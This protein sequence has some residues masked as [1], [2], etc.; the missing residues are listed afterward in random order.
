MRLYQLFKPRLFAEHQV[1][2]YE[3]LDRPLINILKSMEDAGIC[4]NTKALQGL[5][6]DFELKMRDYEQ[7]SYR[8]AGEEFNL[9]SP[10]QIGDILFGKLGAKGKKT[11]TGA[12]QTGA[13]I[14]EDLAA[15]GNELA[16]KILDW[17]AL[18]KLKSTYTDALLA[19]LD[20]Q[21]RVH[22]TYNQINTSTGRLASNNP[23]LQNI[24]IR[25]EEGKKIR[26]SFIA[27][28]GH[29]IIASDYS[30]VELRL[31][32]VVADVKGLKHSFA[33]NQ[34]IHAATASRVF[35]VPLNE[36][37]PNQRRH[38]KAI[39]FGIVYGISQFG[40]AKQIDVSNEEAKAYIDAY[41][42]EMP[43]IKQYMDDTI[44][45]ARKNGY[46][47]TPFGRKCTVNGI[48]DKNKRLSMNAERAAINAP[49]QGG[50]AD[51]IKMAMNAVF[52]ALKAGGFKTRMLLQVHD[53]LVFEAPEEEV[54][55]VSELI[56]QSM[57]NVVNYE[58][59]FIAEVGVGDNWAEAH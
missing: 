59:P 52:K 45:F 19:L 16:A 42:R 18:S 57:Q 4:V 41:F 44:Q 33:E 36:V 38:A 47:L 12:W 21:D 2:V 56:K 9:G 35:G 25:S 22:T 5:S 46:V 24:P 6:R 58:V 13:D 15:E 30:Q 54:A 51:I 11:P 10:K 7:Q 49:I 28:P 31:L 17:R 53:E 55:A 29:K 39:N 20:K 37:T 32:A 3:D 34:D 26:E 27:K 8:L 1:S 40:L 14:L 48:N 50:A 43:E 23:N